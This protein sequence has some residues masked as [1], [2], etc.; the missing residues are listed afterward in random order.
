MCLGL[1]GL[2]IAMTFDMSDPHRVT[3]RAASGFWLH[4]I[5]APAIVNTIALTLFDAGTIPA[6]IMLGRFHRASRRDRRGDRP[7]VL[8]RLRRG[9]R[10]GAR[11]D[12]G[13]GTGVFRDPHPGAGL[14][15]LGAQW[16]VLRRAIMRA[17]PTFPGK[18]RLP[19]YDLHAKGNARV[20]DLTPREIVSELDRFI[21]GQKDASVPSQW[22]SAIGGGASSWATTC[23]KRCTRRT[24]S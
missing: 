10:R 8:P 12:S 6:Q 7:A 19:P 22:R 17:L 20:T 23:G 13:R 14:V 21:I 4:V 9:L 24:S 1:V 11:H 16:E 15:L 18:T 5:A 3:R 2:I